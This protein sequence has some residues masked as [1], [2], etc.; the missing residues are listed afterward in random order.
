VIKNVTISVFLGRFFPIVT[1]VLTL[2]LP[3]PPLG[4]PCVA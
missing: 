1:A 4:I 2:L 3:E